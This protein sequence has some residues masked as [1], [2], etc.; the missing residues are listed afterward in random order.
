MAGLIVLSG[1]YAVKQLK[2]LVSCNGSTYI[3]GR[4][5]AARTKPMFR[6]GSSR[7]SSADGL[8]LF[9]NKYTVA[10]EALLVDKEAQLL[11]CSSRK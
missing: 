6:Y 8:R 4:M 2:M 7:T 9:E 1:V 10:T 11:T 3:P 5:D